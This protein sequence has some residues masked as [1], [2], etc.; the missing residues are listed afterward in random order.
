MRVMKAKVGGADG[1]HP[2]DLLLLPWVWYGWAARLW[3]RILELGRV[4]ET[5]RKA[6][7]GQAINPTCRT[8]LNPPKP[9]RTV[10]ILYPTPQKPPEAQR[11]K[12]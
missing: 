5:W 10:C 12:S 4:P 7:V 11:P 3:A 6:K 8:V 2:R 1:W 9:S